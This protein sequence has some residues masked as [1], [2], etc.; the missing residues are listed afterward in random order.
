[1]H[2][3]ISDWSVMAVYFYTHNV[4]YVKCIMALILGL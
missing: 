3:V 1:M 4:Y 2:D